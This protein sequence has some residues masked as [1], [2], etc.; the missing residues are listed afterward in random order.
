MQMQIQKL[1]KQRYILDIKAP[2][3]YKDTTTTT[4]NNNNNKTKKLST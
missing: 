1:L 3:Q 2:K 4:T